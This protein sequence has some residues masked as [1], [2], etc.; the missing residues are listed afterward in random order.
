MLDA[1]GG[2][3]LGARFALVVQACRGD[4]CVREPFLNFGNIRLMYERVRGCCGTQEMDGEAVH[5]GIYLKSI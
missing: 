3:I 1:E 2:T 5:F 4:V